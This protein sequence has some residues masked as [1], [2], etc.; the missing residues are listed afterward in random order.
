[1]GRRVRFVYAGEREDE[2]LAL[3]RR[4]MGD[5]VDPVQASLSEAGYDDLGVSRS[6]LSPGIV[7][8]AQ[9]APLSEADSDKVRS[10]IGSAIRENLMSSTR[11]KTRPI[12][13][14]SGQF[15]TGGRV[16]ARMLGL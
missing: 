11:R 8:R 14:S 1:M 5:M 13:T 7:V 10:A 2:E 9:G 15:V 16:D 4:V 6:E 12:I 3:A